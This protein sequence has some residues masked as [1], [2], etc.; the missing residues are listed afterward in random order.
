MTG[1]LKLCALQ[2]GQ[3]AAMVCNLN[4]IRPFEGEG[5][6]TLKGLPHRVTAE[7]VVVKHGQKEAIFTLSAAK[8]ATIGRR[9]GLFCVLTALVNGVDSTHR[10]AGGGVVRVDREPAKVTKAA[11]KP[12]EK[13]EKKTASPRPLS[14]LQQLRKESEQKKAAD[15]EKRKKKQEA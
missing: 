5:R 9:G 1:Q 2:R 15:Q 7:P 12:K 3:S 11:E 14:R 13:R 4:P 8:D 6:L 10:L